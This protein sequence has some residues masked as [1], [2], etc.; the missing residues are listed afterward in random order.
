MRG[1]AEG[2]GRRSGGEGWGGA[3]GGRGA[4]KRIRRNMVVEHDFN[5]VSTVL[6]AEK[7]R[8]VGKRGGERS[9][10][11]GVEGGTWS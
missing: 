2:A 5:Y 11:R 9:V 3:R 4:K 8:H 10:W 6:C 1:G 7:G